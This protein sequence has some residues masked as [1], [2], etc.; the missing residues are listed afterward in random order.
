MCVGGEREKEGERMLTLHCVI[1]SN[2]LINTK[3]FRESKETATKGEA[4]RV[5]CELCCMLLHVF[6]CVCVSTECVCFIKSS[7]QLADLS[8]FGPKCLE[9]TCTASEKYDMCTFSLEVNK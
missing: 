2:G 1:I 4:K 6:M 9:L 7:V 8:A 5:Y 3:I